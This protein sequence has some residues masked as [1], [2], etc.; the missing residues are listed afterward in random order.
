M[1]VRNIRTQLKNRKFLVNNYFKKNS[2]PIIKWNK[3]LP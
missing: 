3:L 2:E 1:M